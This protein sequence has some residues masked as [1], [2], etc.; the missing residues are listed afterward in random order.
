MQDTPQSSSNEDPVFFDTSIIPW[1]AWMKRFHL[2]EAELLNGWFHIS[3][4]TPLNSFQK[5]KTQL[6]DDEFMQVVLQ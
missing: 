6:V 4:T 3:L 1:W 5:K 2:P